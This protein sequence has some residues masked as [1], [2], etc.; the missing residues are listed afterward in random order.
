[1]NAADFGDSSEGE[2]GGDVQ[3]EASSLGQQLAGAPHKKPATTKA[4]T[5]GKAKGKGRDQVA[6]EVEALALDG[7]EIETIAVTKSLAHLSKDQKLELLAAQAPEMVVIIQEL[8]DRVDELQMRIAPVR[9]LVLRL[10]AVGQVED[11]LLDYLEMKQQLLLAYC[12]NVTFYLYMKALGKSVRAHPVMRQ[13]L[14][15][16]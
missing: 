12:L 14:R 5:K 4:K 2:E 10:Q 15:L 6:R 9:E 13:M 3:G 1:M 8:R 16:R 7:G 11:D